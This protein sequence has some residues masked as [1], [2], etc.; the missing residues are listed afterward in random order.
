[1]SPPP[2]A[3][4]ANGPKQ[5]PQTPVVAQ[6]P[7]PVAANA[8]NAA[9][10]STT[11]HPPQDL[12]V[13]PEAQPLLGRRPLNPDDPQVSPLR[14][15]KIRFL[16]NLT[17]VVLVINVIATLLAWLSDFINIPGFFSRGRSF[18]EDVVLLMAA[19]TNVV[20]L[21]K[22]DVP[23]KY[24]RVIDFF[25]A[26]FLLIDLITILTVPVL[27]D[28]LG[29]FGTFATLWLMLMVLHD[30]LVNYKVEGAKEYQEIRLT[31][32]IEPRKSVTELFVTF[33]KSVVK[34]VMLVLVILLSWRLSLYAFDTHE[35]PWGELVPVQE[36]QF[37][38]HLSCYGDVH[39]SSLTKPGKPDKRQPIVLVEGGQLTSSEEF[40]EWIEELYNLGSIER[41]CIWDRPGYAFSDS[42]PSPSSIGIVTEYLA[43][44][45]AEQGIEGPFSLV[46]FD[47]G[48]LY[49]RMFASKKP[50]KIH[51]IM[52]VDAWS[53]DLLKHD[54]FS[55]SKHK[56]EPRKIFRHVL[57]PMDTWTGFKLW[58][59]GVVSPFGVIP[60][61]HWLWHPR[62]Y[63]SKSRIF[64][65]DMYY[66]S[67]YLRARLQEQVTSGVLSYNE[68]K[69]A[70][71]HGLPLAVISSD[72]MIKKSQ[73]WGEWQRELTQLSDDLFKWEVAEESDHFIWKSPKGRKQ[74]QKLLLSL[75]SSK[76][77]YDPLK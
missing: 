21:W 46:G 35:A 30:A 20:T 23:S 52:L 69:G 18:Y 67:K 64:G 61:L 36:G 10:A 41:Y 47:I 42:S 37:R 11:P 14:L 74:L 60:G 6:Q 29:F 7:A 34:S 44:A 55:G 63:S 25:Q 39:K 22:I 32:R 72:H 38:V 49:S 40:Q 50:E 71:I 31:G 5:N 12:A 56:K 3:K 24:E 27:R 26:G 9:N 57:E 73:N 75:V 4:K 66:S 19:L 65:K 28:A 8:A 15:P 2:E 48:G 16:Q 59:R 17:R 62:R 70:D 1:M 77:K 76:R 33:I 51:S 45:L 58:L 54:P 13:D 68:L 43:Q 53:E